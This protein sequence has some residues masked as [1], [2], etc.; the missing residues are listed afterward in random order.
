M[1]AFKTSSIA[2][3]EHDVAS[4]MLTIWGRE[5]LEPIVYREVPKR[6]YHGLCMAFSKD[7]FF[8]TQIKGHV[9]SAIATFFRWVAVIRLLADYPFANPDVGLTPVMAGCGAGREKRY[10]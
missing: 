2:R 3:T 4:R 5:R 8:E 6:I 9:R 10:P 1:P 7:S